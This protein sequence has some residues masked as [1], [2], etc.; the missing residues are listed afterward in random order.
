MRIA[1]RVMG[2]LG[3]GGEALKGGEME[4]RAGGERGRCYGQA[5][6]E[7]EETEIR[8]AGRAIDRG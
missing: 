4:L 1:E 3:G 7:S 8:R 6:G 5:E 2:S